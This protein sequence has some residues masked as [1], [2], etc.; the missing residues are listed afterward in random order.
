MV[1]RPKIK[2]STKVIAVVAVIGLLIGVDIFVLARPSTVK[3]VSTT[4]VK[5]KTVNLTIS[6]S[7]KVIAEDKTQVSASL[8]GKAE[9][10]LV[11]EGKLV[12]AGEPLFSLASD[13]LALAVDQAQVNLRIAQD[14]EENAR[15]AIQ[16]AQDNLNKLRAGG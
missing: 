16:I 1:K 15:L 4:T 9:E 2:L 10:V 3:K 14:N 11:K 6:A 7:G 8:T 12:A 5:R 13:E